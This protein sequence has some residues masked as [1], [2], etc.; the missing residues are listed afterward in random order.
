MFVRAFTFDGP[1]RAAV[2]SKPIL[3]HPALCLRLAVGSGSH[4]V[5]LRESKCSRKGEGLSVAC[6]E[7][8]YVDSLDVVDALTALRMDPGE[9]EYFPAAD[10]LLRQFNG[11]GF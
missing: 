1:V 7:V 11:I 8:I 5:S 4:T 3:I 10:W 2:V 9:M 6:P